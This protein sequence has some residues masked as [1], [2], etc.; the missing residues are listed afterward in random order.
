MSISLS[1]MTKVLRSH[2]ST[3]Q[4]FEKHNY[5]INRSACK[6]ASRTST[7]CDETELTI[8]GIRTRAIKITLYPKDNMIGT[9]DCVGILKMRNADVENKYKQQLNKNMTRKKNN[10]IVR[11]AFRATIPEFSG[12]ES[13][14]KRKFF[15]K[16][17]QLIIDFRHRS[18]INNNSVLSARRST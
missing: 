6:I 3:F 18:I 5:I 14:R 12:D 2:I 11:M 8:E 1:A 16:F 15:W 13:F 10:S 7:P 4:V 17:R 9:V